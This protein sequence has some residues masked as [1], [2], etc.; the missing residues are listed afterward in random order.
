MDSRFSSRSVKTILVVEDDELSGRLLKSILVKGGYRVEICQEGNSAIHFLEENHR[1]IDLILTDILMPLVG[2]FDLI[3]HFRNRGARNH[4]MVIT[5][6]RDQATLE[7]ARQLG[8]SDFITKPYKSSEVISRI[9]Q[10]FLDLAE[11][12]NAGTAS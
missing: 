3:E 12:A 10:F 7:R 8:V 6:L 5:S 9:N 4:F 2:G 1:D 11:E